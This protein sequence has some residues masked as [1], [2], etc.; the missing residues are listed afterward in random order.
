[1]AR[2]IADELGGDLDVVIVGKISAPFTPAQT[3]GAVDETGTL[4]LLDDGRRP[5]LREYLEVETAHQLDE[6][7]RRREL[8]T[9]SRP[10]LVL[11][12]RIVIVVDDGIASGASMLAA[13]RAVRRQ[14][15]RRLIVAVP[16]A[17]PGALALIR[18]EADEVI[19]LLPPAPLAAISGFY[20]SFPPVTDEQVLAALTRPVV[21]AGAP[22]V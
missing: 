21:R 2:V 11:T 1:M 17:V 10:P 13:V 15:P 8:Y 3:L 22:A 14:A 16:V 12:D 18:R 7:H 20:E 4:M 5:E 9:S 19:C 6:I